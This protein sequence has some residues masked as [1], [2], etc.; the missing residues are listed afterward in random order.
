MSPEIVNEC[1]L[2]MSTNCVVRRIL[3]TIHDVKFFAIL[4]DETRD[5]QNKEQLTTCIRWVDD[6]LDIH[7]DFIGLVYVEQ[8]NA[9]SLYLAIKY[10][11]IR[12]SLPLWRGRG[13]GLDGAA[14]LMGDLRGLAIRV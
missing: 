14:N 8:S 13:Q 6:Q 7:E 3:N 4:A 10:V 1:I 2:L 9:K 11:H 5:V 12:C